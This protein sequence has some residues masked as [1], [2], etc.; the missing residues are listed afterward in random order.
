VVICLEWWCVLM[1]VVENIDGIIYLIC[2]VE[3]VC[4]IFDIF[5]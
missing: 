3:W 2:V 1:S 4:D 5:Y